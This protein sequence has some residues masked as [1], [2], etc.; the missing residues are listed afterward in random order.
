M[1]YT[2][3][4]LKYVHFFQVVQKRTS[5]GILP[6]VTGNL[7]QEFFASFASI[8]W[9]NKPSSFFSR[10]FDKMSLAGDQLVIFRH[11]TP[12]RPDRLPRYHHLLHRERF[13][14]CGQV[15]QIFLKT[16]VTCSLMFLLNDH[17]N[18]NLIN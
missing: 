5:G 10:F 14:N 6:H 15:I 3:G 12:S 8:H 11:T 1:C 17:R 16:S 9:S 18:I 13:G 4:Q 7:F 2:V